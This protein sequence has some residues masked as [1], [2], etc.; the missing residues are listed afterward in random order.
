M[1]PPCTR[2]LLVGT[3]VIAGAGLLRGRAQRISSE[4]VT[5]DSERCG[6]AEREYASIFA[7]FLQIFLSVYTIR[8][9]LMIWTQ[10]DSGKVRF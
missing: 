9:E 1:M 3:T 10:A 5:S 8:D 2:Q 7:L 4:R 6:I